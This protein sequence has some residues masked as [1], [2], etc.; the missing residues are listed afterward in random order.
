MIDQIANNIRR[1]VRLSIGRSSHRKR[2]RVV[3][4]HGANTVSGSTVR[5][6]HTELSTITVI[7]HL[8]SSAGEIVAG[9]EGFS[10]GNGIDFV[11]DVL[12]IPVFVAGTVAVAVA[13]DA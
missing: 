2:R 12:K 11:E 5:A 8:I 13:I 10:H 6:A 9:V 3:P 4:Y 1:A 7:K